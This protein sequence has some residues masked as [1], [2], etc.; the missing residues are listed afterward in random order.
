MHA[1]NRSISVNSEA[2]GLSNSSFLLSL[3]FD[4][5]AEVC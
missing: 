1:P 3:L 4:S 2:F 5:K